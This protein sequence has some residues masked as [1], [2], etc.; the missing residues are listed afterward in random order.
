[1]T[2]TQLFQR[3]TMTVAEAA[4][5]LGLHRDAAYDAVRRGDLPSL[6]IGRKILIPTAKL[7]GMLG[8]SYVPE[9]VAE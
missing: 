5:L 3:P 2:N 9:E 1:M 8:L 6:R 7:A 4:A